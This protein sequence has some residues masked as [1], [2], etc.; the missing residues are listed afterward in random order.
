MIF[1]NW[2]Y[3]YSLS[4]LLLLLT[5]QGH[6]YFTPF[7]PLVLLTYIPFTP[8]FLTLGVVILSLLLLLGLK[9]RFQPMY[10]LVSN[11]LVWSECATKKWQVTP[12][13]HSSSDCLR[14]CW[15]EK[16]NNLLSWFTNTVTLPPFF[17]A[18]Y[19]FKV[20]MDNYEYITVNHLLLHS[21]QVR[22]PP[23]VNRILYVKNLPYRITAEEM[24][25]IFGK[26]GAIRQIRV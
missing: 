21:I 14:N 1:S 10:H 6:E 24:Y 7:L 23:E 11:S 15:F 12:W 17:K 22:L 8:W 9:N 26:Y 20:L 18:W 2:I 4:L 13:C 5:D 25:D 19:L 16:T 3:C